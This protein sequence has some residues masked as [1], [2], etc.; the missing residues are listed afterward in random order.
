MLENVKAVVEAGGLTMEHVV[1]AQV[2]LDDMQNLEQMNRIYAQ[3]FPQAPP[4]RATLGVAKLPG[5]PVEMNAVAVQDLA[6]KKPVLVPWYDPREPASPRKLTHNRLF[7][8]AMRGR[9]KAVLEAAGLSLGHLVFVNP[10]L[11]KQIPM[12]V[13]NS[14]Y[15]RRFEFGNPPARATIE[16][17]SPPGGAQI[18]YTGV[19]VRDLSQRR[20]VR[21]KNIPPSPT[22][23]PCV[24]AGDTLYCSAKNAFIPGPNAG[25]YAAT[26]EHQL[27]Q[28]F[29]NLLDN[30]SIFTNYVTAPT[31]ASG[32]LSNA[33]ILI[34]TGPNDS[35]I[36][37]ASIDTIAVSP[38]APQVDAGLIQL[39]LSG[40]V[41]QSSCAPGGTLTAT[42]QLMNTSSSTLSNPY[43]GIDELTGG[44]TLLSDSADSTSVSPTAGVTFTFHVQ[45]ASCSTFQLFFD[46]SSD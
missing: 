7:V 5:T 17:S 29:R 27:R 1:Y 23:S 42:D 18:E 43:A 34:D 13:M 21:P 9:V 31:T 22:A 40:S 14:L 45:L 24:F 37:G 20:A 41:D 19:A 11:T 12:K 4:A 36:T 8:S 15:A 16:V 39:V 25:V 35:I 26:I 46:V 10:Y 32:P 33:A 38:Q 2:Y 30:A 28:S 6:G 44:N 3:Y